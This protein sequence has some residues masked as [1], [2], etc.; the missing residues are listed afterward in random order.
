M[1]VQE[2]DSATKLPKFNV[3]TVY[4]LL[5][6]ADCPDIVGCLKLN[7][8]LKMSVATNDKRAIFR[9][10]AAPLDQAGAQHSQSPMTAEGGAV[11]ATRSHVSWSA[12]WSIAHL[13]K[14]LTGKLVRFKKGHPKIQKGTLGLNGNGKGPAPNCV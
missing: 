14:S 2:G 6:V 3:A 10:G 11:M 4:V 12:L 7:R 9:H 1:L 5:R 13:A 8:F